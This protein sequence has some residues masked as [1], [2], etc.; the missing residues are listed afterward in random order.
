LIVSVTGAAATDPVTPGAWIAATQRSTSSAV[1][2]GRA[3]SW[4]T[5]ISA[6]GTAASALRTDSER[7]APPSTRS[8]PS[9]SRS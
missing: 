6:S 5:A 3:A 2:S 7:E 4:T 1:S 8:C 9:A